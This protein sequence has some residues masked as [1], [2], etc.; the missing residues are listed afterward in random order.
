[1]S[2]RATPEIKKDTSVSR[3]FLKLYFQKLQ[4][5]GGKQKKC[6]QYY[7]PRRDV[8]N[9]FFLMNLAAYS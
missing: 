3:N 6:T 1:M 4:F 7:K 2:S 8:S 9:R 5:Q